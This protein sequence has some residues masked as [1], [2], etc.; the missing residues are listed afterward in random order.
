[1]IAGKFIEIVRYSS[2]EGKLNT[3]D[4][5]FVRLDEIREITPC[6]FYYNDKDGKLQQVTA[7]T[8]AITNATSHYYGVTLETVKRMIT[9]DSIIADTP[10]A[11][12]FR[13]LLG[14]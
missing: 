12:N 2:I 4:N 13:E 8:L 9:A 1:M 14:G 5:V 6:D 11:R 3:Y 7:F 10:N